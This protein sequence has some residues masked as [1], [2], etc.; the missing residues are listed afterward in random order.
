M[1]PLDSTL[2]KLASAQ[3]VFLLAADAVSASLWQRQ[4]REGCWCAAEIVEHLVTVERGVLAAVDRV[5]RRPPRP[6]PFF[7]G[8]HFSL[9]IVEARIRRRK[10]P[11]PQHPENLV[12]KQEMLAELRSVRERSR[13][14]LEETKARNLSAYRWPHPF[15]GSL[16]AYQWF[17]F[18]G[19]HQS[20]H[21]K[22]MAELSRNLCECVE[23]LQ[24]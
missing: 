19:S 18:V 23:E 20:R 22:Q 6:I 16:N 11:I 7:K 15:L 8:F 2:K 12:Q 1:T 21:T 14:F 4:P 24:K 10:S 17:R 5:V 13:A 3:A 9:L